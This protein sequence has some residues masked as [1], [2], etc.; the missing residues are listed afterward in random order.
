MENWILQEFESINLGD[1]RLNYRTKK[2][3]S[4][5]SKE[6]LSTIPTACKGWKETK[7]AYRYF[8]NKQVSSDKILEPHKAATI[9]RVK[10]NGRVLVI[11]DT[12]TLDYSNQN[13]KQG[14]G[15]L[16]NEK[17]RG[18]LLHPS[19]IVSESGI[20]LGIYDDYQWFR[21]ELLSKKFSK[22]K[23]NNERLHKRH[24]K[25]KES[26]R[27]ILSYRRAVEIAKKCIDT[28]VISISDREG[29][30]YDLYEEAAKTE[31]KKADW[32]VRIKITHR[33]IINNFGVR[34]A[35]LLNE[36]M[37]SISP[38]QIIE[39]NIP[40]RYGGTGRKIKQELR[41][42]KI[43]LHPPTGRRGEMRCS[44]VEVTVLLAK[45]INA[46]SDEKPVIWWLM[47]SIPIQNISEPKQLI[48]WYLQ[49]WQI[50]IFF[51]IL[52]SGCQVEQLQLE[53]ATRTK[54]C[55]AIYLIIAWRILFL[56]STC[57]II[58]NESCVHIL[59]KQEWQTAWILIKK[60][61][62][63]NKP[64]LIYEAIVLI[65]KMGGYLDRK[66]DSP[67]G[68]KAMWQG[69]TQLYHAINTIEIINRLPTY[70]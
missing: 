64:P 11:Q 67:P 14:I 34:D 5:F 45:E 21:N 8:D 12:T 57:K 56:T 40:N 2:I 53:N 19:L 6:P 7:S 24:I 68:P 35:Q 63:P 47:T 29:D 41:M 70:G 49:R 33:S 44:P 48:L 28:H 20:C 15:P 62:P 61:R 23:L 54:N 27:W 38:Q 25:D 13:F 46:P 9:K 65:A 3:L 26:Y 10:Q 36:K 17:E 55:L 16:R 30:V 4:Q 1:Q 60:E 43:I 69:I 50:E 22:Q 31:G 18:L 52:K 32:L 51:K 42:A 37:V 59:E 66:K 39:F 58:P